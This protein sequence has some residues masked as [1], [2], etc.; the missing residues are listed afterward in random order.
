[1][2]RVAMLLSLVAVTLSTAATPRSAEPGRA[3]AVTLA[4]TMLTFGPGGPAV[5]FGLRRT[6]TIDRVASAL[7][8]PLATGVYPDCGQGIAIAYARFKGKLELTFI[9]GKFVGWSLDTGGS[10]TMRTR[11][12]VGLGT[13]LAALKTAYPKVDVDP[14]SSLGVR[15]DIDD[16]LGGFLSGSGRGAT[17]TMLQSGQICAVS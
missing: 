11:G 16:T 2:R 3:V 1:M 13:S 14:T 8:K 17:V 7:G 6:E 4:P 5:A 12:G 9:A 15:F 10:S